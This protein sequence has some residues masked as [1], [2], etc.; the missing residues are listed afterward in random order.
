M[1]TYRALSPVEHDGVPHAVGSEIA[2]DAEVGAVLLVAGAVEGPVDGLDPD[3]AAVVPIS[4]GKR[5]TR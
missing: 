4:A 2:V 5:K 1:P 3:G